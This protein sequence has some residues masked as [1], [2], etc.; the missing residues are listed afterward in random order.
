MTKGDGAGLRFAFAWRT[1]AAAERLARL[2]G[3]GGSSLPGLLGG[4][5]DPRLLE[6]LAG[7]LQQGSAV[8]TGTNGKTTTATLL[9]GVGRRAGLRLAHNAA[10]ANLVSGLITS[11]AV[12]RAQ[13]ARQFA[14]LEV[15][16]ATVARA[17]PALRPRLLV[18]TNFFRDQ[19]DRYGE[20]MGVVE[21]V[22]RGIE[23]SPETELLLNADDPHVASLARPDRRVRF[24]GL[25]PPAGWAPRR[26]A[27]DAVLCPRCGRPLLYRSVTFAHLGDW[28]CPAC[29]FRRPVPEW[30]AEPVRSGRESALRL[31]EGAGE[32]A[33][34]VR[35]Q[36]PGLYNAYNAVAAAAAARALGWPAEAV[37]RELAEATPAFG[38][39]E[40]F[41]A[42][43]HP[44]RLALVKNPAGFDAV[45][46]TLAGEEA[47]AL[48]LAINDRVADG[49][50]ISWLWDVRF[51]DFRALLEG[52]E[53]LVASGLRAEEMALRLALAGV[54]RRRIELEPD[55]ERALE[56]VLA[57]LPDGRPVTLCLT[58]TALLD[59]HRRL[60]RRYALP[61]FWERGARRG[62]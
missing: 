22:A 59:V 45:L 8:V 24:F 34:L 26:P 15:D 54:G 58:Y 40:R 33:S 53:P 35:F 52:S 57:R 10:G 21:R 1:V 7:D 4:R 42:R 46:E 11:L 49:R 31:R 55:P 47:G 9:A 60:S 5:L 61:A 43:G 36:L 50:D 56:R 20:L 27:G 62:A 2:S 32:L 29:G 19:L 3:R 51:E 25:R 30:E 16:E 14:V 37:T 17:L 41:L 39:M 18:V 6:H 38:R 12:Q 23:A 44:V 48:I 13:G 28:A